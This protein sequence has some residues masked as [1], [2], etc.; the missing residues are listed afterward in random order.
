MAAD[1]DLAT[2]ILVVEDDRTMGHII[3]N[4]L[5]LIGFRDV[6]NVTGG[7]SALAKLRKKQYGLVISDWNM[8]P[9]TGH[10][11]LKEVCADPM[12]KGIPFIMV[13]AESKLGNVVAAKDAGV[14]NYIVKPFTGETLKKKISAVMG[15]DTGKF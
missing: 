13:T 12:L 6:D 11:L 7:D 5:M 10:A 14:D 4:L 9:M 15:S 2:P 3:R 8:T 1:A